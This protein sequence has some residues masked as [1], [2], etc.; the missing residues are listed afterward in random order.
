MANETLIKKCNGRF[1]GTCPFLEEKNFF[2]SNSTGQRHKPSTAD[3][4]FLTCKSENIIYMIYCQVCNI[5]YIGE[6]KQKLIRRFSNHKTNIN[7]KKSGQVVHKHFEESGHGISN[8]RV[9][10]IEKIDKNNVNL[11]GLNEIQKDK[12]IT[13]YRLER[14][15][16]WISKLQTAY[17][18]GLNITVKGVG[19]FNVSQGLYRNFEGR[20]RRKNKKHSRRKPKR[21]RHNNDISMDFLKRKHTELR[22]KDGYIHFFK[23]FLYGLPRQQLQTLQNNARQDNMIDDRL[24][25]MI[26]MI[27]HQ[28]LFKPVQTNIK[29][30][31]DFYHIQFRDKGLDHINI[32]Q[33]LRNKSVTDKIPIYFT[34]K[35]PPIIGYRFNRSIAGN[36]FNYKESLS[37][38]SIGKFENGDI[39]C[40][41]QNSIYKDDHH[42]HVITGNLGMVENMMLRN[43]FKRGPKYRL[44]QRI[45]WSEDKN[46]IINFLESY[47]ENWTAKE[48]K[49]GNI[50][51]KKEDLDL[52]KNEILRVVD[53]KINRGKTLF[54]RTW[55]KRLDGS[56]ATE[57][58]RLKQ[59]FVITVADKAQNNILFTCKYFY[60]KNLKE[61]LTR[62]GQLT[63]QLSNKG[64]NDINKDIINFSKC[65]GIKVPENMGDL[66][67]IY[68]I[69][70][71]H[72]NPIGSRFIAGSKFCSIKMLSKYFSKALKLILQH[73]KLYNRTVFERTGLNCFWILDNSLEFLE[74]IKSER[75]NHMETYDFS[76]LYTALPHGE[77]KR[78]FSAIFQKVFNREARPYISVNMNEAY[79]SPTKA[80]NKFSFR[81]EDMQEILEFILD[82]IY[83]KFGANVYKQVIGIPIGLDSG[84]DIA[85][86]LLYSYESDYV[87]EISKVDLPTARKFKLN[88]RYIDDLFVANFPT[89]RDHI[90]EIYPQDLEIK[91]E[92]NNTQEVTYLDL[93]IKSENSTL[94][95]SVYD[96]RDDFSFDIVNFPYIDSCIPKKSALGVYLSQLIRYAKLSSK[97]EGFLQRSRSLV[98]KLKTQGYKEYDLKRLTSRFFREK[99]DILIKYNIPNTDDFLKNIF[100]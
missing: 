92:S 41:C 32:S 99:H 43:I 75:I 18:F 63:Y 91:L 98:D 77:I 68:W 67:L 79:F 33:I 66:P 93:K 49:Q 17:P 19:D 25:D 53:N 74:K 39:H 48:R 7:G 88:G 34:D 13:K 14:E 35:E 57:L 21:L 80:N 59:D 56:L 11:R 83:V 38:E 70:K 86:L 100:E 37:E 52:W 4:D 54:K 84:Q 8:L 15:K 69:P 26:N 20:R 36:I 28:K 10:P 50:L 46:H 9:I 58:A 47:I 89:F 23:T 60:I 30:D 76:T 61:E 5:Q 27:S 22:D 12:A 2:H 78:K 72:K 64:Q 87:G 82:N 97:Y 65:K 40:N 44:P 55:S 90:Y 29:K 42:G 16:I 3:Q 94:N 85:N 1:C 96:K 24:R 95:F 73:M 31:R 71:M 81:S 51:V 45:N 6:T 62:P